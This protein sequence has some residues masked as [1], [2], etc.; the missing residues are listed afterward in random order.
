MVKVTSTDSSVSS[1]FTQQD[2][3]MANQIVTPSESSSSDFSV[4]SQ[5]PESNIIINGS[6]SS[7]NEMHFGLSNTVCDIPF[8]EMQMSIQHLLAENAELKSIVQQDHIT[9][10]SQ[11]ELMRSSEEQIKIF[12]KQ[13]LERREQAKA[14]IE[15][16]QAIIENQQAEIA[17]LKEQ[18]ESHGNATNDKEVEEFRSEIQILRQNV[19]DKAEECERQTILYRQIQIEAEEL[20]TDCNQLKTGHA[21]LLNEKRE[22]AAIN[23]E[24]QAK[25]NALRS[26]HDFFETGN[27]LDDGENQSFLLVQPSSASRTSSN[28]NNEMVDASMIKSLLDQL[29]TEQ[30]KSQALMAELSAEKTKIQGQEEVI[31]RLAAAQ[32]TVSQQQQGSQL[33]L[34]LQVSKEKVCAANNC[35]EDYQ[36]RCDSLE[37]HLSEYQD[38]LENLQLKDGDLIDKLTEEV[39]N[40]KRMH[41]IEKRECAEYKKNLLDSQEKMQVFMQEYQL[42][43]QNWDTFSQEQESK[44]RQSETYYCLQMKTLQERVDSLTAKLVN[45]EEALMAK[46]EEITALKTELSKLKAEVETIPILQAQVEVYKA[47]FHA[48]R[49]SRELAKEEKERALEEL[50]NLKGT[51]SPNGSRKRNSRKTETSSRRAYSSSGPVTTVAPADETRLGQHQHDPAGAAAKEIPQFTCPKCNMEFKDYHPLLSHV[52]DCLDK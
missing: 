51:L 49:E 30:S 2:N 39:H 32:Q 12:M 8:E 15:N 10:K 29:A 17:A 23:A 18:K 34:Q 26:A 9:M 50:R 21:H 38:R 11:F 7:V 47:D 45:R 43:K 22:L 28:H 16:Q 19:E 46:E 33:M 14:L 36:K 25:L 24:L 35:I 41:E 4:L 3:E 20:R 1:Q 13:Q 48:E 52:N 42:L 5:P 6:L 44:G 37:R 40:L 31:R 27:G